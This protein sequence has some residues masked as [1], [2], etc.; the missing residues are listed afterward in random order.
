MTVA[1]LI[2]A[3]EQQPATREVYRDDSMD[4]DTAVGT[5]EVESF[6][7]YGPLIVKVK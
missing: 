1:E 3:L 7:G 6:Q 5:I 2:E 4:G